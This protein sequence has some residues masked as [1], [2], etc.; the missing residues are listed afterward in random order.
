MLTELKPR[1][2]R[3]IEEDIRSGKESPLIVTLSY[4]PQSNKWRVGES[5]T[6]RQNSYRVKSLQEYII[7]SMMYETYFIIE[8]D[9]KVYTFKGGDV[10]GEGA[11]EATICSLKEDM[12]LLIIEAKE[13]RQ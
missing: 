9:N 7:R 10:L 6:N 2:L 1:R 3:Q 8:K 12:L 4:E 5:Y 11:E 13:D